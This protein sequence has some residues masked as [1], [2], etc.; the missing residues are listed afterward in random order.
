MKGYGGRSRRDL[1]EPFDRPA[2][3]PL[4]AERFVYTEWRQARV[5]IFCG[6]LPYVAVSAVHR[7]DVE[8]VIRP[9]TT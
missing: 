5:N 4:P 1:F 9:T 8:A 7:G 3:R 6:V 2:L